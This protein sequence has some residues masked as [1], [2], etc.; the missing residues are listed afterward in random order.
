MIGLANL[1]SMMP[2]HASQM[3]SKNIGNLVEHLTGEN[4]L[5]IDFDDAITA[6]VVVTHEGKIV[7][8]AL[9]GS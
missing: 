3:Y 2:V 5:T 7:H 9:K 8:P 1:P 6:G 4:G